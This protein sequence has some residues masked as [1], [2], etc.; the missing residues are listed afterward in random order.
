MTVPRAPRLFTGKAWQNGGNA[1]LELEKDYYVSLVLKVALGQ[2]DL[3]YKT[4]KD[5]S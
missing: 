2:V 5:S 3:S 4:A 1:T